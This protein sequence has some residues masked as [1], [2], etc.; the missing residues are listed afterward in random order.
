[1]QRIVTGEQY[2]SVYKSYPEEAENAAEM[3]VARVQGRDIQ[4]DALTRDRVDSP[5]DQDIPAQLVPVVALTQDNL[6]DTVIADGFFQVS[7]ICTAEFKDAC[8]E[9]NLK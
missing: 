7:D 4:F 2:M 5:T 6:E 8:A 9:I 3:A 1:M